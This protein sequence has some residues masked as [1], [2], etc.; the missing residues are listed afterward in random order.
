MDLE[1]HNVKMWDYY[2]DD[3]YANMEEQLDELVGGL[4]NA[5]QDKQAVLLEEKVCRAHIQRHHHTPH[6]VKHAHTWCQHVH[7]RMD[8]F[9]RPAPTY[10]A[11]SRSV[12][13]ITST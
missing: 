3:L 7:G 1:E 5:L 4:G 11:V 12:L 2:L 13:A 10:V 9:C 6:P 8:C